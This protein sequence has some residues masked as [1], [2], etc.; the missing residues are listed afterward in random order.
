M[1]GATSRVNLLKNGWVRKTLK[2]KEKKR[3][4]PVANQL[5]LQRWSAATLTPKN[6]FRVLFTPAA[7]ESNAENSYEME[8]IDDSHQIIQINDP[9][10]QAEVESYF[11]LAKEA[12][13]YPSDFEL[14]R[15]PD[16]RVALLDFDKFGK[17]VGRTVVFPYRQPV[18]LNAVPKEALYTEALAARIQG[19][20][21]GGKRRKTRRRRRNT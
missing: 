19:I 5:E 11:R 10:L 14:Y 9:V 2:R 16:N 15:Q 6:G 13:I 4:T 18:S 7:R 8:Y 20:M 12:G 17:I 3:A 1:E 21:S